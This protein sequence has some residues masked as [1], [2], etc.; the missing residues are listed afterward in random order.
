M[1]LGA[2]RG[3]R[4]LI[5]VV[6]LATLAAGAAGLVTPGPAAAGSAHICVGLV[7]DATSIGGST[8]TECASVPPGSSG[9][10]VLESTGHTVT[11]D[12][13]GRFVCSID[14]VPSSGCSGVD[15]DHYWSYWHRAAGDT[16]WAYSSDGAASYQPAAGSTDGWVYDNGHTRRPPDVGRLCPEPTGSTTASPSPSPSRAGRSN[17]RTTHPAATSRA[18]A[19]GAPVATSPPPAQVHQSHPAAG[20]RPRASPGTGRARAASAGRRRH[21]A[22]SR[23]PGSGVP[24]RPAASSAAAATGPVTPSGAPLW[25]LLAGLAVVAAVAAGAWRRSR[26]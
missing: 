10:D 11:T 6:G 9:I 16:R 26:R 5:A 23:Q 21:S 1:L 24:S 3:G 18:P 7:I 20:R 13:D 2:T 25:Q 19:A 8:D 14:G 12:Y 15:A 22:G 17:S 4:R